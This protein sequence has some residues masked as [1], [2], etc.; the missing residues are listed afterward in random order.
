MMSLHNPY[1][2]M[3]II[4]I[5]YYSHQN[6]FIKILHHCVIC[7]IRSTFVTLARVLC[8]VT[9]LNNFEMMHSYVNLKKLLMH[10]FFRKNIYVR[11]SRHYCITLVSTLIHIHTAHAAGVTVGL[12]SMPILKDKIRRA[13]S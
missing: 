10:T 7:V 4:F 12:M 2:L 3:Y 1:M 6:I 8:Y 5:L 13:N 9:L 11:N